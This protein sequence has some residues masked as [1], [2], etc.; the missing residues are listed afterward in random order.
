MAW[1][2]SPFR[3]VGWLSR[4]FGVAKRDAPQQ[5]DPRLTF[6][7]IDFETANSRYYSACSLGVV[8]FSNG[9]PVRRVLNMIN[10]DCGFDQENI[11]IH[12]ITPAQVADSPKFDAL[13]PKLVPI[14]RE[15]RVV[16]YSDFDAK[17]LRSL[18]RRYGLSV[19]ESFTIDYFDVCQCARDNI[20]RSFWKSKG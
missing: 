1:R 2:N 17:V 10:P 20:L 3:F 8:L 6:V 14:F 5:A 7:A 18:L 16:A 19:D 15:F 11:A 4:L 13:W 12:G 9:V